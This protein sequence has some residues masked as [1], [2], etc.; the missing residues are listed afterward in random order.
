LRKLWCFVSH[1]FVLSHRHRHDLEHL[2]IIEGKK[3]KWCLHVFY[4]VW[5]HYVV[6]LYNC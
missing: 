3:K 5:N 2:M 6:A 1:L 4:K